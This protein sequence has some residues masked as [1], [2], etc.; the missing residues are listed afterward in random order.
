MQIALTQWVPKAPLDFAALIGEPTQASAYARLQFPVLI[1]RGEHAPAPTYFIAETLPNLLPNARVAVV[2]GA[3]HMGPLTHADEVNALIAE[4]LAVVSSRNRPVLAAGFRHSASV[5]RLGA[6][7]GGLPARQRPRLNAAGRSVL[8]G[9]SFAR[10]PHERRQHVGRGAHQGVLA[11]W[12]N[13]L[14]AH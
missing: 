12:L 3:G 5:H 4:H 13:Q 7:K 2:E 10:K 8:D 14:P 6:L 9:R 1:M 11:A